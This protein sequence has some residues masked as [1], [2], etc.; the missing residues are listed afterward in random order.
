MLHVNYELPFGKESEKGELDRNVTY[1]LI[2]E[3]EY[4][5]SQ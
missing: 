2:D 1:M 3:D 5:R 4:K